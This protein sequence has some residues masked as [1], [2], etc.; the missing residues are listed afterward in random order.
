[1]LHFRGAL[2]DPQSADRSVEP[3]HGT[4][5]QN[6]AAA[7]D[8]YR[9]V[10]DPLRSLRGKRFG[11]GRLHGHPF[12][13]TVFLPHGSV[14][15]Q[16]GGHEIGGHS[17]QLLLNQLKLGYRS[18]ELFALCR[19]VERLLQRTARHAACGGCD[20]GAK[21]VQRGHTQLEAFALGAE[22]GSPGHPAVNERNI[23]EGMW[24]AHHQR[25]DE[26]QPGSVGSDHET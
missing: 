13:A 24:R 7:E 19:V 26:L 14:N 20:S 11:H 18:A 15:Q 22:H 23:A 12:R 10:H 8:L 17:R 9:V 2:I 21:P 25:P 16:P 1:M 5:R 6:A 3:V 4:V